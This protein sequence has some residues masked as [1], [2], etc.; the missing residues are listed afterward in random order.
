MVS[1]SLSQIPKFNFAFSQ[2]FNLYLLDNSIKLIYNVGQS[3]MK[4]GKNP[5]RR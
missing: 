5:H 3:V 4:W 2:N 1:R